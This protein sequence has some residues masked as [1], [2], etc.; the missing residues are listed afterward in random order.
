MVEIDILNPVKE[1]SYRCNDP[2]VNFG[3]GIDERLLEHLSGKERERVIESADKAH[4]AH[5]NYCE[6]CAEN[7]RKIIE[8]TEESLESLNKLIGPLFALEKMMAE[9][10]LGR[11]KKMEKRTWRILNE[12]RMDRGKHPYTFD[13]FLRRLRFARSHLIPGRFQDN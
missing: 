10:E 5:I 7:Y 3:Y 2:R 12:V 1:M 9:K 4:E 13:E 6:K 11:K 8:E